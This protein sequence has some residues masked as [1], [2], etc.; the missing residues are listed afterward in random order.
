MAAMD[1]Q[2]RSWEA[3]QQSQDRSHTAFVQAIREVETWQGS[4]G[5]VELSAGYN[6]AWARDDGSYILSNTVSFDPRAVF[7]DQSWQELKR[8]P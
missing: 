7:Q 1:S 2:M 3:R 6:Q 4:G 8:A 5:Q